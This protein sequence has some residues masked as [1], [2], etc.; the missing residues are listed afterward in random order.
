MCSHYFLE[1]SYKNVKN[2]KPNNFTSG[3]LLRIQSF[4]IKWM[5]AFL[6]DLDT[7]IAN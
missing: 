4:I 1:R 2:F 3:T 5:F 7:S 6:L